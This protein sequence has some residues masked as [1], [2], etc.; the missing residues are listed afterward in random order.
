MIFEHPAAKALA[1]EFLTPLIHG[2]SERAD[3][4]DTTGFGKSREIVLVLARDGLCRCCR[5]RREV[6]FDDATGRRRLTRKII[7]T[8]LTKEPSRAFGWH[9][10]R[11]FGLMLAFIKAGNVRSKSRRL[12][13]MDS[14]CEGE[15]RHSLWLVARSRNTVPTNPIS[16]SFHISFTSFRW[17]CGDLAHHDVLYYGL[18][19]QY[20]GS[21]LWEIS[22]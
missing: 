17:I 2:G 13:V 4:D 7:H 6:L 1:K 5:G 15:V 10:H 12:L 16:T 21:G 20:M 22:L 14:C 19:L 11:P 9:F 8:S 3:V 18:W